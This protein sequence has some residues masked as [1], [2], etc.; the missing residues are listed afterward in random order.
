[1]RRP[2]ERTTEFGIRLASLRE[3]QGINVS[4]LADRAGVSPSY[5]S[6]LETGQRPP[7]DRIIRRISGALDVLPIVLYEAAGL[8]PMALAESLRP[9]DAKVRFEEDLTEAER[10]ELLD[11]LSFLRY[12]AAVSAR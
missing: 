5:V 12:R 7:N 11:Y 4:E 2:K 1:M 6:L 3:R 9:A 8:I 10:Q